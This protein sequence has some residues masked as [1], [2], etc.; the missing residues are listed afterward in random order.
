M[1]L[2]SAKVLSSDPEEE[3]L[4]GRFFLSLPLWFL[5][6]DVLG[7]FLEEPMPPKSQEDAAALQGELDTEAQAGNVFR[8]QPVKHGQ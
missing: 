6:C 7:A 8:A 3:E 4:E 5:R 1:A 2:T